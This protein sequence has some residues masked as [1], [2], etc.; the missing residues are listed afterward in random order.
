MDAGRVKDI[1]DK[2]FL[3]VKLSFYLF[4]FSEQVQKEMK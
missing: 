2:K 3:Y 1:L 4:G